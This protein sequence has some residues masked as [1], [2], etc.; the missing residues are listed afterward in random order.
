[1]GTSAGRVDQQKVVVTIDATTGKVSPDPFHVSKSAKQTV[2]WVCA[3]PNAEFTV[4][5]KGET[6]FREKRFHRRA[7]SSGAVA[8][9]IPA[10]DKLYKYDLTI[11]RGGQTK[12]YDP[13]GQ[14][15]A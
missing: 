4:E 7:A 2:E 13:N 3:D 6:P 1:M 9:H 5:F 12:T 8:D 10:G 11:T 14:V 15:D